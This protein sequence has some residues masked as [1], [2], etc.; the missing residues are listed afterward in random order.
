VLFKSRAGV[1]HR[2]GKTLREGGLRVRYNE[3]YSGLAGMMY[4]ADRH[5]THHGLDFLELEFNQV[6][7][8]EPAN[9]ARLARVTERALRKMPPRDA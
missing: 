7:F 9:L 1:A 4:S 8:D 2:V 5:G 6:L 3:P